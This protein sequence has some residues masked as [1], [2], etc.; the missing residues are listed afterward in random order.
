MKPMYKIELPK[1]A[2]TK[3]NANDVMTLKYD[4][5]Q[6]NLNGNFKV[7]SDFANDVDGRMAALEKAVKMLGG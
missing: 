2:V 5:E 6:D 7:L 1:P 3:K 4:K